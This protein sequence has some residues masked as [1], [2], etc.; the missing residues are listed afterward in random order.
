MGSCRSLLTGGCGKG[1]RVPPR[2]S[3]AP[4]QAVHARQVLEL[5]ALQQRHQPAVLHIH[6]RPHLCARMHHR[7][8]IQHS[9]GPREQRQQ[10]SGS[11]RLSLHHAS[12]VSGY[13]E[14]S[15]LIA[16]ATGEVGAAC[17]ADVDASDAQLR[18]PCYA[19]EAGA[20][21]NMR[22]PRREQGRPLLLAASSRAPPPASG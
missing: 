5:V 10:L 9:H 2:F 1:E 21:P 19:T 14:A 7:Y 3:C 22:T 20:V 13:T 17:C 11:C 18:P 6:Q 8:T 16:V 4:E 15:H 12:T